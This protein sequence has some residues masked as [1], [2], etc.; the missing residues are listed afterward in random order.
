[1]MKRIERNMAALLDEEITEVDLSDVLDGTYTGEHIVLP[2]SVKVEV[3]VKDHEITKIDLI[4]HIN[5]QGQKAEI[6]LDSIVEMQS[7]KVDVVSGATYSSIV[8]LK[9]V[10]DALSR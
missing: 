3:T 9:A 7:L 4:R 2:I 5:G 10:Q 1:M 6:L 8:I